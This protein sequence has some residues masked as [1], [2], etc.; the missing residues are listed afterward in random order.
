MKIA[1]MGAGNIGGTL[2]KKWAH[3]GHAVVYGARNPDDA[4]TKRT[5][6]MTPG[7]RAVAPSDAVSDVDAVLFAIP[8]A[9]MTELLPVVG[10]RLKGKIVIDSTNNV[11]GAALNSFALIQKHAPGAALFRAFNTLG[12]ENLETPAFGSGRL[13]LCARFSGARS[14][15]N[16]IRGCRDVS[17][18]ASKE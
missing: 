6:S 18:R 16:P 14:N 17:G 13:N 9:A 7:A 12:W 10:A 8:A 11:G 4:D 3:A 2:G 1:V 5:V 15:D